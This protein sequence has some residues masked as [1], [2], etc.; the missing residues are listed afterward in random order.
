MSKRLLLIS[1]NSSDRGGGERYLIYLTQGLHQIG[2][3][4]YVLLSNLSYMDNWAK[5]LIAQGATV[6]RQ[7]LLGLKHRP[8]RF[9]QSITD[10]KQQREVAKICQDIAPDAILVNQQ[11]DEDGLDYLAG[12]LMANVAPVGGVIH[13]PM[14][15]NK[16][17]RP[18][19]NLRGRLL[20]WWY[21][22]HSYSLILVS[23]GCQKEWENYYNYPCSI[24]VVHHGCSFPNLES[25]YPTT[26]ND[27]K[28]SLPII[29]F[30]GQFVFQK[31]LQLLIDAWL[32]TI[33]KGIKSKLLLIGDG[34]ER[35][36]IENQLRQYA[37]ENTWYITG[38]LE[39]PEAY[40]SMLDIYVMTSHFEGLPLALIEVVG[41]AIP[42]VVTNFN[43]ASD[44]LDHASWVKIAPSP[45]P[46]SVGQTLIESINQ[47]SYLKQQANNGYQNFQKYFSLDRMANETLK[48]LGLA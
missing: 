28:D 48:A 19:G 6:Y 40:L 3:D 35:N 20:K 41:R 45:S 47:L 14:T 33:K 7:N 23:K 46:E 43:G 36:N 15:A 24:Q 8:L 34:P 31:N 13:L 30:S 10:T 26:L 38:W 32:W 9:L 39:H 44:V 25:F 16:A 21:K 12:A 1:S 42:A 11:Y 27:W 22:K 18:L 29:G 2:W 5:E 4:V 37:P 17:Q